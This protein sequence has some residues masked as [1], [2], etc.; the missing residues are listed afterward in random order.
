MFGPLLDRGISLRE[1]KRHT[2]S[3][4]I[5]M[6]KIL[7]RLKLLETGEVLKAKR[8]GGTPLKGMDAVYFTKYME[9]LEKYPK[10]EIKEES[11]DE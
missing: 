7:S 3:E 8:D 6:V 1:I 9:E 5:A 11:E 10:E 2:K 4:I